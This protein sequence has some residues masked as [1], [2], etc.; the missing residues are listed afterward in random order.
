MLINELLYSLCMQQ[1][2]RIKQTFSILIIAF[3]IFSAFAMVSDHKN[4]V[5]NSRPNIIKKDLFNIPG[6]TSILLP[7]D[8]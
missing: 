1:H 4:D 3:M 8:I 7:Q 6:V 2:I 5:R